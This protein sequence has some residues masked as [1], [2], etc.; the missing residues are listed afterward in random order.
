MSSTQQPRSSPNFQEILNPRKVSLT[1]RKLILEMTYLTNK[2]QH[3]NIPFFHVSSI[4]QHNVQNSRGNA[5]Q[6]CK[7]FICTHPCNPF[8]DEKLSLSKRQ[9]LIKNQI[10]Q[11]F[12]PSND[13]FSQLPHI[14]KQNFEE[15]ANQLCP[16]LFINEKQLRYK[17][18]LWAQFS[19][20]QYFPC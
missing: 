7:V 5:K 2:R 6:F 12:Y 14:L 1:R 11:T 20:N 8:N 13:L 17:L 3:E 16:F 18:K 19:A 10:C 9:A 15:L 4:S